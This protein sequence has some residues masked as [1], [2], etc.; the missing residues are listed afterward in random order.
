MNNWQR[1]FSDMF[2][3][4]A[5]IVVAVLEDKGLQPVKISKRD[6]AYQLGHFEVHVPPEE[7]I[8]AI[9]II[10]DDIKFE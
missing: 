6:T 9:K 7:V 4:R 5:E 8:R 3:Y 10:N 2:E 1:V